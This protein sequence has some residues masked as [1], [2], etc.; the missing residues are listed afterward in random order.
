PVIAP[1][2]PPVIAPIT[3]PVIAPIAPPVVIAPPVIK[4]V[5]PPVIAPITPPVVIAPPVIK[6]IAPPLAISDRR[7]KKN[8]KRIGTHHLGI[9]LYEFDYV[10]GEHAVGVMADEVKL[11]RPEAV[12]HRPDGYDM[13]DYSKLD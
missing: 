12:I 7:L 11:V 2:A 13:V 4:P 3:P 5:A 10:W 8:I 9:G 1:I 6:P